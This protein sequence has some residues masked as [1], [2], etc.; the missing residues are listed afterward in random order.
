MNESP[1]RLGR[2]ELLHRIAKGGMGEIFL[3]KA[4]GAGGFEKNVILKTILPHLAEEEE[5]I[6]KFLDE[7]RIVV[8]LIHGN[9][10]PVFD[11]GEQDGVFFI[12]ME[13]VPGRDLR[14]V[15][16][17]LEIDR[18]RLPVDLAL[19][20]GSEIAKG[21]DYAHR[22]TDEA[23][24]SLGIVHR[25]ISPSNVLISSD[26]EVK[27]IDFGIARAAG[28]LSKT[29]S[30]R[31]QGKFCY[32]SPEQASGKPLDAR[33]DVFSA[34][35]TIYEMLTGFRPFEGSTDL[36]SLDLVRRCEFDP[37]STL[38]AEV[39][40][41]VDAI[42]Q[43]A[44]AKEP[45]DRYP[46]A[47][48]L[49]V[50]I[51]QYLY[52]TGTSPTSSDVAKFLHRVFPEGLERQELRSARGTGSG[53]KNRKLSLDDALEL[54][55][56]RMLNGSVSDVDPHG[57]TAMKS[58]T[59]TKTNMR[60]AEPA[61]Q[62]LP[63]KP[64]LTEGLPDKPNLTEG[65]PD[66]PNFTP[67]DGATDEDILQP[68]NRPWWPAL[69]MILI[70]ATASW[71]F[72][73]QT[74]PGQLTIDSE[75]DGARISVDGA[76]LVGITTPATFALDPGI[77]VV[78]LEKDGFETRTLRVKI[79]D[80]A[81]A[82][83]DKSAARLQPIRTPRKFVLKAE[84]ATILQDQQPLG[85]SPQTIE[86]KPNQVANVRAI[87]KG[88]NSSNY[89]LSYDHGDDE[90]TL[91]LECPTDPVES[92]PDTERVKTHVTPDPVSLTFES[93]PPG[94]RVLVDSKQIGTTPV[95]GSY[96]ADQH[97]TIRLELDGYAPYEVRGRV[98][99]WHNQR[100]FATLEANDLGCLDVSLVRPAVGEISIDG[101]PFK[102]VSRGLRNAPISAGKHTVRVRNDAASRD[103][104]FNIVV[105]SGSDCS[106][107]V[108]E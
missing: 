98:S 18:R 88:C 41:E 106:L 92:S 57:T 37:P 69:L 82:T 29:V 20:I 40:E 34:G 70:A 55:L 54:E 91:P 50:D 97:I 103:D 42:V 104:T 53:S 101:G 49:Q 17:R 107:I 28:R 61:S 15:I 43:R 59:S 6:T 39:P 74:S 27:L 63:D 12:A 31:I 44:L 68:R 100:V 67:S 93:Q 84:G 77:H 11:M 90:I 2:Y 62:G 95:T 58:A 1:Q 4:R 76:E 87:K 16:K 60:R 30:G 32:M 21:L 108:W 89:A 99:N 23:G 22:K 56:D 13:Y 81:T 94:A 80:Q 38:N 73:G 8:Q 64:N 35:I 19:F 86:L 45:E 75:P 46:S 3:A 24:E 33:S 26:G 85:I 83:V 96:R 72:V 7:G 48:K 14:E 5:F 105:K 47:E 65:L 71:M 36:E 79:D 9:I 10:V 52:S 66:K 51:L 78:A 25:D 102:K